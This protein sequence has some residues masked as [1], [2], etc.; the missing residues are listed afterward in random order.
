MSLKSWVTQASQLEFPIGIT[1]TDILKKTSH[2]ISSQQE[3]EIHI[4]IQDANG[5][6]NVFQN[7]RPY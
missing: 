2:I 5:S 4:S 6:P 3:E 1:R 7:S